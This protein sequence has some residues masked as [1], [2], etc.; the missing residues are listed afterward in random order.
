MFFI[1]VSFFIIGFSA[2][3]LAVVLSYQR[4]SQLAFL[5]IGFFLVSFA[6]WS[7]L[8]IN[9]VDYARDIAT[10]WQ[11]QNPNRWFT[12]K[13]SIKANFPAI[14]LCGVAWLLVL[15]LPVRRQFK[16]DI[17][18]FVRPSLV[19]AFVLGSGFLLTAGD[20]YEGSDIPLLLASSYF[21][22]S[23]RG[24]HIS[25]HV[26]LATVARLAKRPS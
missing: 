14:A 24:D 6:M 9:P 25:I 13:R 5:L 4:R 22:K 1:K 26:A 20:A 21:S 3:L 18:K 2:A 23:S 11:V 15:P 19:Y 12:L 16:K 7:A 10:A 8:S 17:L